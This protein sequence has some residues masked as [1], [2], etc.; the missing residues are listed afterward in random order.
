MATK[1]RYTYP[2]LG[3]GGGSFWIGCDLRHLGDDQKLVDMSTF[4]GGVITLQ[5]S[6]GLI[7]TKNLSCSNGN[8]NNSIDLSTFF[9]LHYD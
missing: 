4:F 3:L 6:F 1:I 7:M 9:A 2:P 5:P 8:R